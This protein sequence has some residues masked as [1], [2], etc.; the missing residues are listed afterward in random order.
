[1][2]IHKPIPVVRPIISGCDG[3]TKNFIVSGDTPP[4]S[5]SQQSYTKDTTVFI[6]FYEKTKVGKDTIL[7]PMDVSS[8]FTNTP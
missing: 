2:K 6:N 3:P 5:L 8:L 4:C 1:M 7:V